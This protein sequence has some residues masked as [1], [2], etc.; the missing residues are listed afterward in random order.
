MNNI[1]T[2]KSI[3]G[4]IVG[5][6][7][8]ALAAC[9]SDN[10]VAAETSTAQTSSGTSAQ[11]RIVPTDSTQ[12]K[13]IFAVSAETEENLEIWLK[14]NHP[15]SNQITVDNWC[16]PENP[17]DPLWCYPAR[18]QLESGTVFNSYH[19]TFNGIVC[20]TETDTI[21]YGVHLNNDIITKRWINPWFNTEMYRESKTQ[22]KEACKAEG[23]DITEDEE[24]KI[25]CDIK[26][27][28]FPTEDITTEESRQYYE[29][30]HFYH[31]LD[32][33]WT[34]FATK[35][36][37]ACRIRPQIEPTA[38][39][40]PAI[41]SAEAEATINGYTDS[42][43]ISELIA[44]E[45]IPLCSASQDYP[46][47]MMWCYKLQL[48]QGRT[49]RRFLGS[50][51]KILCERNRKTEDYGILQDTISY[52][53][54]IDSNIVTKTLTNTMQYF[55]PNAWKHFNDLKSEFS[56]SCVAEGGQITED[57]WEKTTCK[58]EIA[59]C[60][61]EYCREQPEPTY[62][63][64]DPNWKRFVLQTVK[65]CRISPEIEPEK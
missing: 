44:I 2:T 27:E 19:G 28:P 43:S 5:A 39:P 15:I 45:P 47:D 63:Y 36:I 25:A 59:P 3:T 16:Y 9:S 51:D 30:H 20:E 6:V 32:P 34:D 37:E 10:S 11:V 56:D 14:N 31:Y 46:G 7:A 35:A 50:S 18:L 21:S 48:E 1:I 8:F 54:S 60:D 24:N 65:A 61:N 42:Y 23:G 52:K 13:S 22:F 55:N 58:I 12:S 62:N 40:S 29:N 4:T 49:S 33:N 38:S 17:D 64:N 57:S 26:I 41:D 53:V